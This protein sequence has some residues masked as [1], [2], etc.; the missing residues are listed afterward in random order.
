MTTLLT[1]QAQT[2][3]VAK[4]RREALDYAAQVETQLQA[5]RDSHKNTLTKL[6]KSWTKAHE[7]LHTLLSSSESLFV[8]PKSF[9]FDGIK[10]GFQVGKATI[11]IDDKAE[12]VRTLQVLID[13]ED[14]AQDVAGYQACLRTVVTPHEP[15]LLRLPPHHLIQL[16]LTV[17]P[18]T[19]D[20]LIKPV[21]TDTTK[22]VDAL[23]KAIQADIA[24]GAA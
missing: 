15:S 7:D 1:I 5:V 13:T 10:V 3:F 16:P 23:I 22:A 4:R 9:V 8:S 6:I 14:D 18:A 21:D 20:V 2:E 19:N 11:D 17:K 24:D 12:L